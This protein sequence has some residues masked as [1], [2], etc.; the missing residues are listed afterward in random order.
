MSK[1]VYHKTPL[2]FQEQVDLLQSRGLTIENE[3]EALAYLQEIS[4]YRLSAYFSDKNGNL[5]N[6]EKEPLW[7]S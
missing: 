7:R 6:W 5:K 1:R 4:Y 3:K 2:T